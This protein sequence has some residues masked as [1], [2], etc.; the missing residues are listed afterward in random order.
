MPVWECTSCGRD[1]SSQSARQAHIDTSLRHPRCERCNRGFLNA[2]GLRSH[3]TNS[4]AHNYCAPCSRDFATQMALQQHLQMAAVHRDEYPDEDSVS[5]DDSLFDSPWSEEDIAND[6][7]DN[8]NGE[9]EDSVLSSGSSTMFGITPRHGE[10]RF[11]EDLALATTREIFYHMTF[12]EDAPSVF[13]DH[14][15]SIE[16]SS[17]SEDDGNDGSFL[18][19]SSSNSEGS[20]DVDSDFLAH[21][22]DESDTSLQTPYAQSTDILRSTRTPIFPIPTPTTQP[23]VQTAGNKPA[24]PVSA[25]SG[26]PSE[27]DDRVLGVPAAKGDASPGANVGYVCPLCLEQEDELSSAKCGHVFCTSCVSAF[28]FDRK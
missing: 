14:A 1:F 26:A 21:S 28:I 27:S 3:L 4:S 18:Y 9:G 13:D 24:L 19:R 7:N 16:D 10:S 12:G 22:D 15:A 23:A 8:D 20:S 25:V 5:N 6:D 2:V 11:S 17:E